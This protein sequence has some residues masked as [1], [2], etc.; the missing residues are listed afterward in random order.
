MREVVRVTAKDF[1]FEMDKMLVVQVYEE[2]TVAD[3]IEDI[4][5][6]ICHLDIPQQM[7]NVT[8]R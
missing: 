3:I 2:M 5:T 7:L 4:K 8:L 6:P 1:S